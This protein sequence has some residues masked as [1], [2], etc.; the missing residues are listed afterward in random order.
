MSHMTGRIVWHDL[1]STDP[2]TSEKFYT[3]L[4]GWTVK[5][6]DV[7]DTGHKYR[8]IH[9]GERGLGGIETLSKEQGLPPHWIAYTEVESVD[10]AARRATAAGGS[11]PVPPTDIPGVGRFAVI[12]D[13]QGAFIS[14]FHSNS[15]YPP[16]PEGPPAAGTFCWEE[17]LTSDPA[18]AKRF[19]CELFG[20]STREMDMG[21]AGTYT[22]FDCG[23]KEVAGAMKMPEEAAAPPNWLA[24]VAVE[25]VDATHTKAESLGAQTFVAPR[26]IPNVGRFAVLADPTGAPFAIFQA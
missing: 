6:V 10:D 11:T 23:K 24:Y 15:E 13:P 4:F 7:G 20:W 5:Q 18:D 2:E 16:E 22:L 14:A 21:E 9:M 8:M 19:Y 17:L 25:S 1:M 12:R 26:D 3:E